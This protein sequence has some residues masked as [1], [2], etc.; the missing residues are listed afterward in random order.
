MWANLNSAK[1]SRSDMISV[2]SIN[3][4]GDRRLEMERMT[5]NAN[6]QVRT[7]IKGSQM[8]FTHGAEVLNNAIWQGI[9]QYKSAPI[10]Q[11]TTNLT[12]IPQ[13][14]DMANNPT[15]ICMATG[16]IPAGN[17]PLLQMLAAMNQKLS[18]IHIDLK[19]LKDNKTV[20]E[21]QIAGIQFD[22]EDD[23]EQLME[24]Q[25]ELRKCQDQVH[26]LTNVVAN[27]EQK[28]TE[29][30]DKINAM[31]SKSQRSEIIIF[32]IEEKEGKTA[33]Q[34]AQE[35]LSGPMEIKELPSIAQAYWKGKKKFNRPLVLKMSNF[36]SKSVVFGNVSK[37]K[38]KKNAQGRAF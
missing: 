17:E 34:S 4:E 33:M 18:A 10:P 7:P 23:H 27:Y 9:S 32:G 38:D 35:F 8:Q 6:N 31:E 5:T 37:L 14:M 15:S 11:V 1:Q 24:Q 3:N 36:V 12:Q 19:S 26:L 22:L 13:T 29:M 28:F 2:N 30:Q 21:Q 25:G 20:M 16:A